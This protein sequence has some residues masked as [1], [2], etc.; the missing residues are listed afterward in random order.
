LVAV[1][2]AADAPVICETADEGRKDDIAFLREHDRL[3]HGSI[4][5]RLP[6][7][8]DA[9]VNYAELSVGSRRLANCVG[10]PPGRG[11]TR[12]RD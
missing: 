11:P 7:R 6:N 2:K 10:P 3:K 8:G 1:V 5:E 9:R 4:N 12:E